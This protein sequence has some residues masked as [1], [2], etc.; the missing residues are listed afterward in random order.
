MNKMEYDKGWVCGVHAWLYD[1]CSKPDEDDTQAYQRIREACW[2]A[3][4]DAPSDF[5]Q[6]FLEGIKTEF[7]VDL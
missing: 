1:P 3:N 6:G 7:G 2:G 4:M 5:W